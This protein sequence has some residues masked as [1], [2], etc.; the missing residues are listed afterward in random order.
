M[1]PEGPKL[2]DI[3]LPADP[4][5]WPPAP[6]WWLL[7]LIAAALIA[8]AARAFHR[9][10]QVRRW[11]RRVFGELDRIAER[12]KTVPDSVRL[13]GEV[14]HLLRRASRLL[15]PAAPSLRGEAWMDFLD[16]VLGG[17]DFS[18]GV[19]RSLLDGPYRRTLSIDPESLLAL[20]RTWLQQVLV[21]SARHA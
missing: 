20:A 4:S 7:A 2:L 13:A 5:W 16:S 11:R 10:Q 6:G 1:N 12:Q 17:Q 8:L 9:R 15:D 21:R 14:S 3:H 18:R 19:G